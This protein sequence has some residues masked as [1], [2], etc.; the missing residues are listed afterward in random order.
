MEKQ[1]LIKQGWLRALIFTITFLFITLLMALLGG[2]IITALNIGETGTREVENASESMS[3]KLMLINFLLSFLSA[4]ITVSFFRRF[5]DKQSFTSL[6]FQ[7]KNYQAHAA[8]GFFLGIL[9]LGIGSFVL[10]ANKNLQWIDINFDADHL[11]IG[12]GLMIL[13]AFA[14]ESV[15]R[16]YILSNLLQSMNKWM[17][18]AL[19]ALIFTIFHMSNQGITV[20]A[21][22]NVFLAGLVLGINYIY[23]K[24]LWFGILLHFSWNFYQGSILGY[25]VS[26]VALQSLLQ[27]Q[28]TGNPFLTGG[29]FGF[30]GSVLDG[31]LSITSFLVLIWIYKRKF[32][33]GIWDPA[34][35]TGRP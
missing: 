20:I 5:I 23:T 27:Q 4:V 7:W 35:R 16:G 18:L 9:L 31:L 30:E 24:N 3:G 6:G 29:N 17:A 34:Y 21:S 1:P 2:A 19:S 11:F 10:I 8:T 22:I 33:V 13:V 28:L 32:G 14:E 25:K 12:F 15:F 26:G